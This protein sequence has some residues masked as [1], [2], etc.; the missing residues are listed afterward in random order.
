MGDALYSIIN[1][2]DFHSHSDQSTKTIMSNPKTNHDKTARL[3][4]LAVRAAAIPGLIIAAYLIFGGGKPADSE[5]PRTNSR[6]AERLV[7]LNAASTPSLPKPTGFSGVGT[8]PI[9]QIKVGDRVMARNPEVTEEER[10][11]WEEPDWD[12]WLHLSL[13]MPKADGSELKIELLRPESWVLDQMSYVIEEREPESSSNLAPLAPL[14]GRGAGGEGQ[15]DQASPAEPDLVPLSPMRP[16]YRQ[17]GLTSAVLDIAGVELVDLTVEMDLPEMGAIGTAVITDIK[18]CSAVQTGNGQPVTATF[19]HPPSTAVL[20]VIFSGESDPIG[21]TDNH[22]FWSV[23]RQRFLPIGK[24]EI[25]ETVQTFHGDTK[26]IEAKLPRPGPQ[27]VYNLEVYGEHV[28]FVGE[29]GILAHNMYGEEE[30]LEKARRLQVSGVIANTDDALEETLELMRIANRSG[31]AILDHG[32]LQAGMLLE[33][34]H[35]LENGLFLQA[36]G[37]RPQKNLVGPGKGVDFVIFDPDPSTLRIGSEH[38]GL[39]S[40]VSDGPPISV[41]GAGM[42]HFNKHGVV[43]IIS[44]QSGHYLPTLENITRSRAWLTRQ[45]FL[46]PSNLPKI[47][48][49]TP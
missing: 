44:D 34:P 13:V 30:L 28:Y 27:V 7:S 18:P 15:N 39:A 24:M 37:A 32:P 1:K 36:S 11:S 48:V 42:L 4:Q 19:S 22:L 20:N 45:G 8:R 3:I 40:M 12:Q 25:G 47:K 29:Q 2:L 43:D 16:F 14:A 31:D 5:S 46:N 49:S 21:V 23:D 33:K 26:R 41:F 35:V 10:A 17:L 9:E 38:S 6:P